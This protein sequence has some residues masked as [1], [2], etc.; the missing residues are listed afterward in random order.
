MFF[1]H[2]REEV[3]QTVGRFGRAQKEKAVR[4]LSS[5]VKKACRSATA[6]KYKEQCETSNTLIQKLGGK[7]N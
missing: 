6:A 4:L 5:F 2:G 3:G 7:V 1:I